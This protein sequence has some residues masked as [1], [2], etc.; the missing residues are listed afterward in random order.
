MRYEPPAINFHLGETTP[1][2]LWEREQTEPSLDSIDHHDD[3]H[4]LFHK[5][6]NCVATMPS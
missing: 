1:R 5:C 6:E 4:Q 3:R 2:E